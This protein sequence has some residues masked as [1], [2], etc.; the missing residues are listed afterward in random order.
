MAE[1]DE[2]RRALLADA[3]GLTPEELEWPP[4]PGMNSIGMP[5]AQIA[6]AEAHLTQVGVL[7]EPPTAPSACSTWDGCST[8]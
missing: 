2:Q 8:T 5:L 3:R 6:F 7:G 1:L 4:A